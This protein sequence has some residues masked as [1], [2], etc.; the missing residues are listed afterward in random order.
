MM[1]RGLGIRKLLLVPLLEELVWW[2]S[3]QSVSSLPVKILEN[4]EGR[5]LKGQMDFLY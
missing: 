3:L 1:L 5:V 4:S 2:W